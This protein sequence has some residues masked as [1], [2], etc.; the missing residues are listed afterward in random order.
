MCASALAFRK[1][2]ARD[3]LPAGK[4]LTAPLDRVKLLLQTRGGFAKGGLRE[5]A[6]RGSVLDSLIAIGRQEGLRGYWRGNVPQVALGFSKTHTSKLAA[7]ECEEDLVL[8][9][10]LMQI[11]KVIPYSATQLCSYEL[12]KHLFSDK[13]GRVS[14]QGRLAAGAC[15]GMTATLVGSPRIMRSVS[16]GACAACRG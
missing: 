10:V 9:I 12:F 15:A 8:S 13:Q 3:V 16:C 2:D 6:K 14:V 11:L 5:A 7:P 4:T 1:A